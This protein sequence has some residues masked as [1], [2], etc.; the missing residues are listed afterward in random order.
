VALLKRV[1]SW[2][3]ATPVTALT[4]KKAAISE[5][6]KIFP[7]GQLKADNVIY[8]ITGRRGISRPLPAR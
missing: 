1:A 3:T 2:P 8:L 4:L 7:I 6:G 5:A